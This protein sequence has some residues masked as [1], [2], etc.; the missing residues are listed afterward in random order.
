MGTISVLTLILLGMTH[1]LPDAPSE[2]QPDSDSTEFIHSK[3]PTSYCGLYCVYAAAKSLGEELRLEDLIREEYLTGR[4]GSSIDDLV[5]ASRANGLNAKVRSGLAIDD[6]MFANAPMILHVR[7]PG[8]KGYYHWSLFLGF[9]ENGKAEIYDP[10]V[11]KG[12]LS[13]ATVLSI[14]DGIAIDISREKQRVFAL[15]FSLSTFVLGM[16]TFLGLWMLQNWCRTEWVVPLVGL[17][18][19]FVT[20]VLPLGYIWNQDTVRHVSSSHFEMQL[21]RISYDELKQLLES[22]EVILIDTRPEE[23]FRS[24]SIPDAINIPIGTS[25]INLQEALA[26]LQ[27]QEGKRVVTY[28]QSILC[29]WAERMGSI[30]S[31]RTSIPVYVYAEGM[32]GWHSKEPE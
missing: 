4:D 2:S 30:I 17:C 3:T 13:K 18:L 20:L 28:C 32:N 9:D 6:L 19:G 31:K 12:K 7:S 8:S 16:A 15:P 14:W 24:D 11:S 5:K 26:G 23:T 25:E 22:K 29:G 27:G 10:P 1:C 21:P